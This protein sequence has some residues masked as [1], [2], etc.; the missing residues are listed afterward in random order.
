MI[1][2][3][4][5][6]H[7]NSMLLAELIKTFPHG[8]YQGSFGLISKESGADDNNS[9]EVVYLLKLCIYDIAM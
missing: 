3:L 9:F 5:L 7:I 4:P 8:K 2:N 1:L 6:P